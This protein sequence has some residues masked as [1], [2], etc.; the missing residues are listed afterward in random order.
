MTWTTS[1]QVLTVSTSNTRHRS[2]GG[3]IKTSMRTSPFEITILHLRRRKRKGVSLPGNHI[4]SLK[5]R[6]R[7]SMIEKGDLSNRHSED[8][9]F[10]HMDMVLIRRSRHHLNQ[11]GGRVRDKQE[12][13]HLNPNQLHSVRS[14]IPPS[15]RHNRT[16]KESYLQQGDSPITPQLR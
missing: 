3:G 1:L 6:K 5:K 7:N 13:T 8:K 11:Q 12:S 9:V 2:L 4:T 15:T 14:L 16:Y 10:K